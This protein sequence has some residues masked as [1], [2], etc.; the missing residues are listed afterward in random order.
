LQINENWDIDVEDDPGGD[1][2]AFLKSL[3]W[4]GG[5]YQGALDIYIETVAEWRSGNP[6]HNPMFSVLYE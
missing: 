3:P 1:K 5:F 4:P 6:Y 2:K